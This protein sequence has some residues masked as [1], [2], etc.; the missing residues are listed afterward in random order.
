MQTRRSSAAAA[1]THQKAVKSSSVATATPTTPRMF[2]TASSF[3][4]ASS[5]SWGPVAAKRTHL[6]CMDGSMTNGDITVAAD[7]VDN[8]DRMSLAD[9]DEAF[10]DDET[11]FLRS[12]VVEQSPKK[13]D[14]DLEQ[15]FKS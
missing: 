13:L 5:S 6:S 1:T 4:E 11:N 10:S 2:E 12:A 7:N 3:R 15:Q 8:S 9:N 14:P